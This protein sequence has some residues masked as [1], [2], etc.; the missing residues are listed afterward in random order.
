MARYPRQGD[1]GVG[2]ETAVYGSVGGH[3]HRHAT[4]EW[5]PVQG[6]LPSEEM[7]E[8]GASGGRDLLG[9]IGAQDRDAGRIDVVAACLGSHDRLVDPACARLEDASEAVDHEVVADV[10]PAAAVTVELVDRTQHRRHFGGG[11]TVGVL[12]VMDEGELDCPV[13][14]RDLGVGAALCP[15]VARDDRRLAWAGL[16]ARVDKLQA[17]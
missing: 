5:S 8:G 10:V 1:V 13:C 4:L 17:R 2:G 3:T 7:F 9:A 12:G 11:I 16:Q 6:Q 14:G 15:G